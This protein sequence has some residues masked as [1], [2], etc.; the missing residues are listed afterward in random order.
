MLRIQQGSYLNKANN[1]YTQQNIGFGLR[2]LPGDKPVIEPKETKDT[3]EIKKPEKITEKDR[4][5]AKKA[6]KT[7]GTLLKQNGEKTKYSSIKN[8]Q[9]YS[10]SKEDKP[11]APIQF[12]VHCEYMEFTTTYLIHPSGKVEQSF[13]GKE[14]ESKILFKMI[15]KPVKDLEKY[16]E[17]NQ[18]TTNKIY[19]D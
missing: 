13:P 6:Y 8:N 3:V 4:E 17:K 16:L 9:T 5:F 18:Y 19:L 12:H 15:E 7:L 10:I 11:D 2:Y 14:P 1:L